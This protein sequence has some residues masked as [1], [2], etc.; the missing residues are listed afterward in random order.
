MTKVSDDYE[1]IKKF[2][3]EK[4]QGVKVQFYKIEVDDDAISDRPFTGVAVELNGQ[5]NE[6]LVFENKKEA[7]AALN[8]EIK[9]FK[10]NGFEL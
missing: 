7:K 3:A 6:D 2:K 4:I 5:Y 9:A 10:E 1:I 8:E